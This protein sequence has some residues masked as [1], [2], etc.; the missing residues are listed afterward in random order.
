MASNVPGPQDSDGGLTDGVTYYYEVTSVNQAGESLPSSEV[1]AT[2]QVTAPPTPI[3]VTAT[4]GNN[5]VSLNWSPASD[6]LTYDLYRSTVEGN[7]VVY[8]QGITGTSFT[9]TNTTDG[10]TY[11]YQVSAGNGVGE[12]NLSQEVSATPLPALPAAPAH[13]T[14]T[15]LSSSQI[16]LTWTE[17]AGTATSFTLERS[18]DGVNFTPLTMLDGTAATFVDAAGLDPTTT[19]DYR[20]SATNLAGNSAWSSVVS[21][22]PLTA[23]SSPWT[24]ADIGSP[25]LTGSAY[26]LDGTVYVNGTGSDIWNA[27]DQFHYVYVPLNGN[28]TIIAQVTTQGQT[29][30]SAKAGVMI[31]NTLAAN[32]AFADMVLTPGNGAAFQYRVAAGNNAGPSSGSTTGG[33]TYFAPDWV[34]LVRSGSTFTGY[35]ST[36]GTSWTEVGSGTLTMNTSVYIGLCVS[37]HNTGLI[38][39]ATFDEISINGGTTPVAPSNLTATAASGTS[40]SLSWTN[41]D[42]L[43]FA[44][45]VYRQNPGSSTFTWIATVP[46]NATAYLDTG[47]TPG[48]SYSYQVLASNT[49]GN[50]AS[51]TATV[52][53]PVPPLAVSALQP[54]SVTTTSALLSWVLNSSN[55]T[56]VQVWRRSGG[57]GSF[58]LATTLAAGSTSYVDNSLQPG[59]LYEYRV[60]AIDLAGSSPAADTGLTTVPLAPVVTAAT[61]GGQ[62]QL[63]WTASNGAVSYNIYRGLAPAGEDPAPYATVNNATAFTDA[64]VASGLT[65]YYLVTA[66]DFSGESAPSTEVAASASNVVIGPPSASYAAGGPVTYTISYIDP[67]FTSSTLGPGDITLNESGT[68]SGTVGV[69][70]TGATRI[71]AISNIT[72]NGSLGISIAAGTAS[73]SLGKLAGAAGPSATFTVDNIAPTISIGPPS[74]SFTAGTPVTYTVTYADANFNSST[75]AA[76]NITLNETGSA[77]GTIGVSG[78]GLTRTVTISNITGNGSLGISIAA[79]TASDLA[80]NLAPAAGPSTTFAVDNTAPTVATPASAAPSL[81]T[82]TTTA[83]SVLGADSLA[84]ESSLTYSWAATVVPSGAGVPLFSI[85]GNNAAKN[86]TA[87][88][89]AAGNYTFQ[90]TIT[91]DA[92]Q[93][94]TSSVN[95]TV[96]QTLNTLGA[97]SPNPVVLS[98][99][100]QEQFTVTGLDQF[101]NAMAAPGVT[102]T[103]AKGTITASG[104]YTSPAAA[105][106]DTVAAQ[107]GSSQVTA[108]VTIVAPVGWWQFNEGTGTTAYD[109]SANADNGTISGATWLQPPY[110]TPDGTPALQFNGSSSVVSLGNPAVLNFA[111]QITLSAWIKPTS[112]T[113]NQYIIDHRVNP[114]DDLFLM[115][116]SS[117]SYSVGVKTSVFHGA[118]VAIPPHDL[119]TWVHLVGTY[120]GTTWR[121]YRDGQLVASSV[122]STGAITLSTLGTLTPSWG[123]GAATTD[124]ISPDYFGGVIDDVRIYNTAINSSAISGLEA[125]PPTVATPAAATP[126]PVAGTTA[127]LSVLGADDAGQSALTYT[128]ATTGTPPAPVSFSANGS[129]AAQNTTATF[130]AAGT[131]NFLV[132]I[133]DPAGLTATSSVSVTVSQTVTSIMLSPATANLGSGQTQLFVATAYD[134]FGA[135]FTSP[136]AF[137]WSV[138][139]GAG[140]INASGLYT[141]SYASGSASIQVGYPL[142]GGGINSNA[143][144]VTITDA[145]PAVAS[146]AAAVPSTV[147]GT[148][149]SLS[150]LGADADGGGEPNLTYTW[151]ASDLPTGASP[152]TFSDNGS[153]AAQSTTVTFSQA[154]SYQFTVTITD[155]GGLSTTSSVTV[156]VNQTL[157]TITVSPATATVGSDQT[158]QFAAVAYDQFGAALAGAPSG[159]PAYT[160]S[161]SSGGGSI[162]SSGLYTAPYASGLASVQ[163]AAGSGINSNAAVVTIT[164]AAPTVASPAAAVPSTVTGTTTSLSVLGADADGGGE[165]NLTYTWVATV[166]PNGASPPT[167]SVNGSNAAQNTTATFSQAGSYQFTVT[168]TDLGGLS[169][170]SSVTVTVNQTLTSISNTGQPPEATA[171]ALDQFGNPLAS[172]PDFDPGTDTITGPLVL[173]S[174]VTVLPAAG[175]QLTVSGGISGACALTVGGVPGTPGRGTVVLT[176]TNTYSGGTVVSAGTLILANSSAIAD[177]TG[178]TVGADAAL[179][180]AASPVNTS[181]QTTAASRTAIAAT[182]SGASVPPATHQ[183]RQSVFAGALDTIAAD[184]LVV[185]PNTKRIAADLAWLGQAGNSADNSD[186]HHKKDLAIQVLD[187]MFAQFGG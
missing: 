167:F 180:F 138:L 173:G 29:D 183:P 176:G 89:T 185:W 182:S 48:A 164:D 123:I 3:N 16:S 104:L 27:S 99:Q 112:I 66:V 55:N 166:L 121:L 63:N 88:F 83:L 8:E 28:G 11:Y 178:L 34:E 84:G 111:G 132:T 74:A 45:E 115:I 30:P 79:G 125:V 152:P 71:V 97:I 174:N 73:N 153:N 151:A 136:P 49:V 158:Q 159:S 107:L 129:N 24:D 35:V 59:T 100:S 127:A 31:R 57:A 150:V 161:V 81:V 148:T 149:T 126:S 179:I 98:T 82:G 87:T 133:T 165:P 94:A 103:A 7:E 78:S 101:G 131:Y 77:S 14:A 43:S 60:L 85:N 124:P 144:V 51:N 39:E 118:S 140:S 65:Y 58:S 95:V 17:P 108:S 47:L 116:T 184:Q 46:A 168:I 160:W 67:D 25:P 128:W 12:S 61:Q 6:A 110:G 102:W 90:V 96:N 19:Y 56:G 119:N 15:T 52:T 137:T 105:G 92:G 26:E 113:T 91:N 2:P 5:Q 114:T 68:A 134:Q 106:S 156:T 53:T 20:L 13:L 141:A 143:A 186:Q 157:T 72:G 70:G 122:D 120:D 22:E 1:S 187:A 147:T 54:G 62:V 21:A 175:S 93:T 18:V 9:D 69:S 130:T 4:A 171:L 109:S 172:Q 50:T 36:N 41:N 64:G 23:V 139:S 33:N 40:V 32:S 10:V 181:N 162:S 38:S 154:G 146:P 169:I 80:G 155:L 170:T 86:T 142:G 42:N 145:A 177:G 44:N 135:A 117:G 163:A 76:A 75:L 37:S